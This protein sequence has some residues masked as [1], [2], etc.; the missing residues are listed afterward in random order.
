MTEQ[1]YITGRMF[2][3]APRL[4]RPVRDLVYDHTPLL[5]KVIG[6]ATPAHILA[7]LAEIDAVEARRRAATPE[8]QPTPLAR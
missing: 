4:L 5:Q 8:A 6:D 7:Q 3:R 1:A 2:H